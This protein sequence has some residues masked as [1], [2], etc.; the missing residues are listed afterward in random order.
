MIFYLSV[1]LGLCREIR[2][3]ISNFVLTLGK[4]LTVENLLLLNGL[5]DNFYVFNDLLSLLQIL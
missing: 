5:G 3:L 2:L 1:F 4:A